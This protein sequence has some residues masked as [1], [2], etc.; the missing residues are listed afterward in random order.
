MLGRHLKSNAKQLEELKTIAEDFPQSMLDLSPYASVLTDEL[1]LPILKNTNRHLKSLTLNSCQQLTEEIPYQI[2]VHCPYILYLSTQSMTWKKWSSWGFFSNAVFQKLQTL[3]IANCMQLTEVW[4][5]APELQ[6]HHSVAKEVIEIMYQHLVFGKFSSYTSQL[7]ALIPPRKLSLTINK[8]NIDPVDLLR[9]QLSYALHENQ[10]TEL[11]LERDLSGIPHEW[12]AILTK[13]LSHASAL[14]DLSLSKKNLSMA[15]LNPVLASLNPTLK[16]LD[17]SQNEL[18]DLS[19]QGNQLLRV[20]KLQPSL[21]KLKINDNLLNNL[22]IEAISENLIEHKTLTELDLSNNP[23]DRLSSL[24]KVFA[25]SINLKKLYLTGS[26]YFYG[27]QI[28]PFLNALKTNAVLELLAIGTI[29]ANNILFHLGELLIK[30]KTLRILQV[31]Q[32]RFT[33][34]DQKHGW[35]ITN[36][37]MKQY[38]EHLGKNKSLT[39]LELSNTLITQDCL[40][41]LAEGIKLNNTLIDFTFTLDKSISEQKEYILS[42]DKYLKKI[43]THITQNSLMTIYAEQKQY[44]F[45]PSFPIESKSLEVIKEHD[46]VS[47]EC[48]MDCETNSFPAPCNNL[49]KEISLIQLQLSSLDK[50]VSQLIYRSDM[51]DQELD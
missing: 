51:L 32:K 39:S 45:K 16:I 19:H 22:D 50:K 37:G 4:L 42:Y 12:L 17:I 31:T 25:S 21:E 6:N 8:A 23:F 46:V 2:A 24:T 30:N 34:N 7:S 27:T 14:T 10:L 33:E 11:M 28:I 13:H 44:E 1:L 35:V 9:S 3:S 41:T 5:L 48:E 20:L 40:P 47:L 38:V 26:N 29:S 15:L 18:C 49:P 43:K 36:D